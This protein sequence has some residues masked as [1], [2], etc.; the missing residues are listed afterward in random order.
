MWK[1]KTT[2]WLLALGND[3]DN[4]DGDDSGGGGNGERGEKEKVYA[5]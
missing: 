1:H 3:D 5:L 4:G 2:K